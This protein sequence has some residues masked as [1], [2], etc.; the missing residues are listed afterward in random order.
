MATTE[1]TLQIQGMT[2]SACANTIEK[3]L[4]K[5]DGVEK[6]NVNFAMKSTTI[7]YDPQKT[8]VNDFTER[9]EK[10]GYHI[11][12]EKE[13]FDITGMTCSAC[14]ARIE[15]RVTK[16]D[17]VSKANVNFAMETIAVEYD[18]NQ[19][20]PTDMI[21][22]VHKMGFELIPKEENKNKLDHKQQEIKKQ[23]RMFIFSLVLT[24]PLLWTMVAHFEFLSF[25][26]MPAIL[27]NPWVQ[28]ALATP[29][30]F[31]VGA[32]FS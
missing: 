20:A 22:A 2:C 28:L 24:L 4:S 19:I 18:R 14:A 3:G 9:V 30:Q 17:G 23:K 21:T 11:L 26:Y 31:I 15:K 12:Q 13:T 8:N 29:V 32:Q 16:M 1:K 6:A 27:M 7:T 25:I 5:I 10:L